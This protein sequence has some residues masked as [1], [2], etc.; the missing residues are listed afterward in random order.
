[1]SLTFTTLDGVIEHQIHSYAGDQL[2][3]V[4]GVWVMRWVRKIEG[5]WL[6]SAAA[7]PELE[8]LHLETL[9]ELLSILTLRIA[10][11][12]NYHSCTLQALAV[13][14]DATSC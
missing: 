11:H 8:S 6:S 9:V 2:Y 1:M 14:I 7:S 4:K 3:F 12:G 13:Y 5:A 10:P